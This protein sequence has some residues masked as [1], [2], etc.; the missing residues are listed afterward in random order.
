VPS[1][2]NKHVIQEQWNSGTEGFLFEK[3]KELNCFHLTK[4][5]HFEPLTAVLQ[6]PLSIHF[7]SQKYKV[8]LTLFFSIG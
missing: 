7:F 8:L 6:C 1:R 2:L 3:G 5:S 4:K